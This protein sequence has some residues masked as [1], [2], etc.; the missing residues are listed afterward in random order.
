MYVQLVKDCGPKAYKKMPNSDETSGRNILRENK[1]PFKVSKYKQFLYNK[2]TPGKVV[3][4]EFIGGITTS[5]FTL[6]K[7]SNLPE[8]PTEK[9]YTLGKKTEVGM[10]NLKTVILTQS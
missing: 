1:Q 9:A 7:T 8:L 2:Y 10:R 3:V 4:S 6:L 5:T